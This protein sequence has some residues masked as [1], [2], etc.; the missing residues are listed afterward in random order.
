MKSFNKLFVVA[1]LAVCFGLAACDDGFEELNMNPNSPEEVPA[2]LLLPTV[3]RNGIN[4]SAGLAWGLGNVVMQYSAKIQFTNEDRYNW[5]PES[6]PYNSY[7]NIMRD[8]ENIKKIATESGNN[9][10]LGVAMVYQA[11]LFSVLTDAY[12][13]VPYSEATMAKEG[14][15]LPK[16]DAQQEIYQGIIAQLNEANDILDV[17]GPGIEGD[18]LF[19]GDILRWKK[20]ANSLLLRIHLRLSDRIDPSAAMQAIVGNPVDHPIMESNADNVALQYL[21]DLP[22]QQ[23]LYTT[24][25]GSFDEYRLSEKM[26][27]TLKSLNDTRLFAYAQPTTDSGAGL[28][29]DW[30]DYQGVPNGLADEEALQYS[31]SGDPAKGGSNFISRLGLMFSCSACNSLASPIAR[32]AMIM[33]YSELQFILAEARERGFITTGTAADYYRNGIQASF[34]YYD[35]RLEVGGYHAIKDAVEADAL[36]YAQPEVAYV[37]TPA[38]RLEKIAMQKW[39]ANFFSGLEAWFDWRRTGV[40]QI[41]PGPGAVQATVP[42]RFMYPSG[43]QA[44][45]KENYNAAIQRQGP[46]NL[47]TRVWWDVQ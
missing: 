43:V 4:E 17:N 45:N 13:D 2:S 32:Q 23:P 41:T 20:F 22:N 7:Y 9:N 39:I 5:G 6:S 35:E 19:N 46:D 8:V 12:G 29:G 40:P 44:L 28:V 37:G 24:R 1:V 38:Q 11:W 47:T 21:A 42:V 31:P 34:D 14:V 27:N 16:F 15:N 26:E 10:F 30:D 18:I 36:Y 33:S 3:L 25:S